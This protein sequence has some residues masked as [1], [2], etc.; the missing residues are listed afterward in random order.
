MTFLPT[1]TAE[2]LYRED[3]QVN[4]L[5]A[6]YTEN[7]HIRKLLSLSRKCDEL[8]RRICEKEKSVEELRTQ[9]SYERALRQ[10][11]SRH[12][13]MRDSLLAAGCW[14]LAAGYL[15]LAASFLGWLS[16]W[17]L[18]AGWRLAVDS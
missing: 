15:L 10:H 11:A 18:A 17:R 6:K 5:G 3:P 2:P 7:Y 1:D 14:L 9:L 4:R 16:G 13:D 12:V 8:E